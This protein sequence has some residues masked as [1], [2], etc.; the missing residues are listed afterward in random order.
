MILITGGAGYIGSHVAHL[1][2]RYGRKIVVLDNLYSGHR[3]AVPKEIDLVV[4]NCGDKDLLNTLIG[5]YSIKSVIHFAA[6]LEV[7]ESTRLPFKYYR[8]NFVN[9]LNLLE[10]C[11][12]HGISNFIFSSTC[13]VYGTPENS[14]VSET[15][16]QAPINPYGRSKLMI[17]WLLKDLATTHSSS[18]KYCILRYFNVAGAKIDGGL[19]QATPNA[20]QLIKVA[21]EVA[22]GKRDKLTIFGT[23][24]PTPDGTCIR[25]Y[26]HVEDLANAHRLALEYL[27][28]GGKS[29]VFNC[30]YGH[31]FSVKEVVSSMKKVTGI[32]FPVIF[33]ERRPG[34]AVSIYAD[35]NKIKGILNWVPKYNDIDLICKSGFAWEKELASITKGN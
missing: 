33:A 24:Y 29:E 6:H 31:G 17:E 11:L 26:I 30:G 4:G 21:S 12:T 14:S 2:Q 34:D 18:L 3:W 20:T 7:E 32:D 19:G 27:E 1:L 25:D 35:P 5:K 8:N 15:S 16:P 13:A 22:L 28:S 23:D 9:T 10:T